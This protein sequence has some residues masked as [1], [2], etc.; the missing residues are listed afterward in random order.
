MVSKRVRNARCGKSMVTGESGMPY[1]F[2][3]TGFSKINSP[4]LHRF[5]KRARQR[6]P[7]GNFRE[8]HVG[9]T[10]RSKLSV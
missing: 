5:D 3:Y 8:A 1:S 7:S 6:V 10:S 4:S 9:Q 2:I